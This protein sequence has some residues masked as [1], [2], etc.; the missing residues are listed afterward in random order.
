MGS[1]IGVWKINGME[2]VQC[3]SSYMEWFFFFGAH[4]HFQCDVII[5]KDMWLKGCDFNIDGQN[6][7]CVC[8][9]CRNPL[10]FPYKQ[11]NCS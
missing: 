11:C 2:M 3:M 6:M 5:D 1:A 9:C 8:V 7:V 4:A 10:I